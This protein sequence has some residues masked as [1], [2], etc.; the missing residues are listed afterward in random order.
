[1]FPEVCPHCKRV[2]DPNSKICPYCGGN[3]ARPQPSV[4]YVT[5]ESGDRP[6]SAWYLVPF[7]FGIIG[8]LIA[9]VGVKDEDK[10]M[11]TNLLIFGIVWSF[12]LFLIGWAWITSLMR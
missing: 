9:Y 6:S 8:G 11:A 7:L 4:T 3:P 1:M 2:I 10:D 12:I 5:S